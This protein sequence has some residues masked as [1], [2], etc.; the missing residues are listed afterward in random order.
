M[1]APNQETKNA[2]GKNIPCVFQGQ[3][4]IFLEVLMLCLSVDV[5]TLID[6]KIYILATLTS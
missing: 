2:F 4:L 3:A 6:L 1:S 5:A